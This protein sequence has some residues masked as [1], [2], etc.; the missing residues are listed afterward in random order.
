VQ[1]LS[2]ELAWG[3]RVEILFEGRGLGIDQER[4]SLTWRGQPS[5][6]QFTVSAPKDA[7]GRTFH[8]RVL[9]LVDSVP[10]GS[11]TFSLKVSRKET[12]AIELRG[13]RARRY[14]YA[15]LSYASP[16]RAEVLKRAQ[17]LKAGG[18]NFFN[19][20]LSLEPG[21]RWEKRLYEEID[22]CDVFYLFWSSHAK[23][24]EWV[25]KETAH[26]LARQASSADG[27]PDIVPVIIE[28][29]PTPTPPDSLKAI[30]FNDSLIYLLASA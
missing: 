26:A 15:F 8:P 4:Q 30:H 16:D 6:C 23:T 7:N 1:T 22:R 17:G 9:V 21:E 20:L 24:S 3:Q 10:V 12:A 25:M 29:P 2:T 19:D 27:D 5:A 11:L 13:D 14:S 18:T 28:G